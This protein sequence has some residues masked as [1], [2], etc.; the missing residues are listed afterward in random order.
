MSECL[1]VRVFQ[2]GDGPDGQEAESA[3][4]GG[5]GVAHAGR[6]GGEGSRGAPGVVVPPP[7]RPARGRGQHGARAPRHHQELPA[8]RGAGLGQ[9]AR[10]AVQPEADQSVAQQVRVIQGGIVPPG[11]CYR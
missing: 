11:S 8:G 3:D 5:A 10:P 7:G 6:G 4:A 2:A 9:T 1:C